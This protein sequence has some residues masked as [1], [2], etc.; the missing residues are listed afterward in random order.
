[1]L[2]D[3]IPDPTSLWR[4]NRYHDARYMMPMGPLQQA[5]L[6]KTQLARL[7]PDRVAVY[8]Y[9]HLPERFKPQRRIHSAELPSAH[10]KLEMMRQAI[11]TLTE[12]GYVY[13]GMDHFALPDDALAVAQRRALH[14]RGAA[15]PGRATP[16]DRHHA[17][18]RAC[19]PLGGI[20]RPQEGGRAEEPHRPFPARLRAGA[21]GRGRGP[22][23]GGLSFLTARS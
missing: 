7:R 1:M 11:Q 19:G 6:D 23:A 16:P 8:G 15:Q 10:D 13:I 12:H 2:L 14:K 18:A 20:P 22:A 17:D 9:A 3:S 4:S 21:G 5:L